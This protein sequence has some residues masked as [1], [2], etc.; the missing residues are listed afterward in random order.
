MSTDE[1]RTEETTD[2]TLSKAVAVTTRVVLFSKPGGKVMLTA[3]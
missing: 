3:N 2:N 1:S